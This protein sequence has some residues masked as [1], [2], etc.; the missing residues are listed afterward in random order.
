MFSRQT[1][2]SGLIFTS[3]F[4]GAAIAYWIRWVT[5]AQQTS[6]SFLLAAICYYWSQELHAS[7]LFLCL[8]K[9]AHYL[10]LR[11]DG[12]FYYALAPRVERIKR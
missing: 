6:V 4:E 8:R 3:S 1:V 11:A 5:L 7:K 2:V 12:R 9:V 10:W